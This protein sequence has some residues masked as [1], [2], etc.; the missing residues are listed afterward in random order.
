[1]PADPQV[2]RRAL[3]LAALAEGETRVQGNPPE[4]APM[5][6]ALRALGV[7][8]EATGN[9]VRVHGGG[10]GALS[11]ARSGVI[12]CGHSSDALALLA[13]VLCAQPFG[14]RLLLSSASPMATGHLVGA[15]AARGAH[16]AGT[17]GPGDALTAPIAIAPL[18]Q[19]EPLHALECELP[20][21]SFSA[22]SAILLSGLF[23]RG[24][25]MVC[26]PL[27]SPDHTERMLS[28]MGVPVRRIGS[29]AGF[30]PADWTGRLS[31]PDVVAL[32]GDP[33]L[34]AAI[35]AA[36]CALPGS[37]VAMEDVGW[38]PT[39]TGCFDAMRLL[40]ARWLAI[41][42]GDRAMHEPVA[43]LQVESVRARGGSMGGEIVV[44]CGDALP[45]LCVFGAH[46]RRGLQLSDGD[47]YAA[48]SDPIWQQFARLLTAFGA[49]T[50][51]DGAGLR[52]QPAEQLCAAELDACAD[53]RL[54]WAAVL[55]GLTA[56]GETR[57]HNAE[58]W[59][60]HHPDA[61]A[62][63]RALGARIE[64]VS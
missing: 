57:V 23:S 21:P 29:M 15:L 11:M 48:A 26:E 43:E 35:A 7:A 54:G 49:P 53:P 60:D 46:C 2:A 56:Q 47:A 18:L 19:D 28:T 50:E 61:I 17:R 36:A 10:L 39:R 3:L 58:A 51:V 62:C 20:E 42:K 4:L 25:T 8:L 12:D 13:G 55:C 40:G 44:R 30:E 5:L 33:S 22:K 64:V 27:V 59:I 38:N 37:R 41:A 9:G 52:I 6:E 45:A 63:L 1:M 34:A 32:P 24:A 31:S 16:I 14:T